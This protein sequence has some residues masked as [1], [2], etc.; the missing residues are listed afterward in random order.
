MPGY[1]IVQDDLAAGRQQPR[2]S[3]GATARPAKRVLGVSAF[4]LNSQTGMQLVININGLSG[5]GYTNG[6]PTADT[7]R[8]RLVCATASLP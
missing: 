6:I 2:E 5:I 1:K 8:V 7:L 4:W 3:D